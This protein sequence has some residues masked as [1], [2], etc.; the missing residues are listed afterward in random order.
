MKKS[1]A[2]S[3]KRNGLNETYRLEQT[4]VS[5]EKNILQNNFLP[6]PSPHFLPSWYEQNVRSMAPS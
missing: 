1:G 2:Q 5:S 3:V 4:C 6:P